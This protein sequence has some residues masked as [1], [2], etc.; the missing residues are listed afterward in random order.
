M[1]CQPETTEHMKTRPPEHHGEPLASPSPRLLFLPSPPAPSSPPSLTSVTTTHTHTPASFPLSLPHLS[2]PCSPPLL[3]LPH[4]PP[5][6]PTHPDPPRPTRP[7]PTT[8]HHPKQKKKRDETHHHPNPVFRL[9]WRPLGPQVSSGVFVVRLLRLFSFSGQFFFVLSWF[10]LGFRFRCL[11][12]LS[13]S[14][15]LFPS[16][17]LRLLRFS[18]GV[19]LPVVQ[20]RVIIFSVF[21]P[22]SVSFGTVVITGS[23]LVLDLLFW[24]DRCVFQV[25]CCFFIGTSFYWTRSFSGKFLEPIFLR[26]AG[27]CGTDVLRAYFCQSPRER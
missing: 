17:V 26:S 18:V 25:N 7:P 24:G 16:K 6:I 10:L 5:T 3:P 15:F 4:P 19:D 12:F 21:S 20:L 8:N 22:G 27:E 9:R 2:P 11:F 14:L 23:L 13:K 1:A